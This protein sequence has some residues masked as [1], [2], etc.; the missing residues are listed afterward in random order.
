MIKSARKV[1]A[2]FMLCVVSILLFS[3]HLISR[4]TTHSPLPHDWREL[5]AISV[6]EHRE[7]LLKAA[8]QEDG[9][10]PDT[11]TSSETD[12]D[13]A[14]TTVINTSRGKTKRVGHS[15][16]TP[17][18]HYRAGTD[19]AAA[20]GVP[21]SHPGWTR[22]HTNSSNSGVSHLSTEIHKYKPRADSAVRVNTGASTTIPRATV[23]HTRAPGNNSIEGREQTHTLN[24]K[25]D[26]EL[27]DFWDILNKS[28]VNEHS[29][30]PRVG[31]YICGDPLCSEFLSQEDWGR[32]DRC[33]SKFKTKFASFLAEIGPT[34]VP[35][36]HFINRTSQ[37]ANVVLISFPG[38]GNT[39]VRALLEKAT[40][41]CTGEET[42]IILLYM[43]TYTL[44][45]TH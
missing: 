20:T 9:V 26:K 6:E 1:I 33:V 8:H 29:L 30:Q 2:V 22:V 37:S 31:G 43:Y 4:P 38:S 36:C 11:A 40:S 7:H 34:L 35:R 44:F 16:Q 14:T 28:H 27:H 24:E 12:S 19:T 5:M 25:L 3:W 17:Q 41:I 10:R 23:H 39:W 13:G 21:I 45:A 18:S 15:P 42:Y 32:V